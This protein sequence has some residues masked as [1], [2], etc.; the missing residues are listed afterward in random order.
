MWTLMRTPPEDI[1]SAI[2]SASSRAVLF[3][4]VI[5]PTDSCGGIQKSL[6]S[7]AA[8]HIPRSAESLGMPLTGASRLSQRGFHALIS[9][10][11][12]GRHRSSHG[13]WHRLALIGS[14]LSLV[15]AGQNLGLSRQ[16]PVLDLLAMR[17]D[18]LRHFFL[19]RHKPPFCVCASVSRLPLSTRLL[20]T[21]KVT[22]RIE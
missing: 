16:L 10:R 18:G 15:L 14:R 1:S 5:G 17:G 6:P 19:L 4:F 7:V 12:N 8:F 9:V 2:N 21:G 20:K 3:G 13:N 11:R 22:G